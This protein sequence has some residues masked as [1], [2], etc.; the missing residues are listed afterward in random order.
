LQAYTQSRT[1]LRFGLVGLLNTAFGY[2]VFALLVH[3]T[4]WPSV[5]LALSAAAGTAFNFQTSRRLVF[6]TRGDALRFVAVYAFVL[7]L[8]WICLRGLHACGL[9]DLYAQ[10]LLTLPI[11]TLSFV[12]QRHFVF[13]R[14]RDAV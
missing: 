11:A 7:V 4:M 3:I 10:A 9:S 12:C 6:H 8:N 2:L 14:E 5:A 1:W 13:T